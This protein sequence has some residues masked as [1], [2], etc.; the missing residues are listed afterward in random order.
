MLTAVLSAAG[1]EVLSAADGEEGLSI[2]IAE[3]PDILIVDL[4][5][6]KK[7]GLDLI[8]SLRAR[9]L[10]EHIIAISGVEPDRQ[11][12]KAIESGADVWLTKPFDMHVLEAHVRS[13]VRR[14]REYASTTP[15]SVG[16][17]TFDPLTGEARRG[18][19]R[20]NLSVIERTLTA[21]GI[22]HA[23]QP[24]SIEELWRAAWPQRADLVSTPMLARE[25]HAVEVAM[26]RLTSKLNGPNETRILTTTSDARRRRV[27]YVFIV[28]SLGP[29]LAKHEI[30]KHP[31]RIISL[32]Y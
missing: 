29:E 3:R 26:S 10:R 4:V 19:R 22:R 12:V 25:I 31:Q 7:L 28:P 27:G 20:F 30:V 11:A 24:L 2:A 21:L 32:G 5:L 8:A 17:L 1:Y 9:G 13:G 14:A 23:G 18:N 16:D 15:V 6:P